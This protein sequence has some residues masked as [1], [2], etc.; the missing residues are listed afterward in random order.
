VIG[1]PR[2]R[3]TAIFVV[4]TAAA[5]LFAFG[6]TIG[7]RDRP[8]DPIQTVAMSG[9]GGATASIDLFAR[10]AAGNWPMTLNVSG[11]A[12]LPEGQTYALWLT[13]Q[14]KLADPCG[15]FAVAAGTTSVPLNAPFRLKEYDGWVVVRSG[16]TGPVL[17]RSG[18][19]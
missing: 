19:V 18:A 9:G 10:D 15:T 16:T 13:H 11:L 2:R 14:G 1:L 6:Y 3:A 8:P 12:P 7:G 4:A 5:A 17:L